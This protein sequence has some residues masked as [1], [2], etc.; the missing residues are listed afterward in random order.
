VYRPEPHIPGG[1]LSP[2]NTSNQ[3][4]DATMRSQFNE[5]GSGYHVIL[6]PVVHPALNW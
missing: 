4:E 3:L 6:K 2:G 1:I 5:L